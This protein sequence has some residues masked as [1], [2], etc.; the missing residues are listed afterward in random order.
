MTSGSFDYTTLL[1]P[2]NTPASP[3]TNLYTIRT[4]G[5]NGGDSSKGWPAMA[6]ALCGQSTALSSL[7]HQETIKNRAD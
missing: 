2:G 3:P 5:C 6:L 1:S 7:H 4:N